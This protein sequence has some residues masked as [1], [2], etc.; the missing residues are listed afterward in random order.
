MPPIHSDLPIVTPDPPRKTASEKYGGLYYLGIGGLAVLIILV[1]WFGWGL[2]TLRSVFHEVYVLHDRDRP[3]GDRIEAAYRLSHNPQ[4]APKQA[5]EMALRKPLPELARYL[6]AESLT[7]RI[8]GEDPRAYVKAVAYSEGWPNWLR[9]VLLRPVAY[10]AGQE[11]GLPQEPLASLARDKD[12]VIS[13]W[14]A[15]VSSAEGAGK[16]ETSAAAKRE[17][18][19]V[20]AGASAEQPLADLFLRALSVE[21]EDR[22]RLLDR[23][24]A[25]T[26]EHHAETAKLWEGWEERS[27]RLVRRPA[28]KLQLDSTGSS[29]SR[30]RARFFQSRWS[31]T[32]ASNSAAVRSVDRLRYD[33]ARL[34]VV[35]RRAGE[36]NAG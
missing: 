9:L 10:A 33:P 30:T 3:D 16:S 15:F 34:V 24:T 14:A 2:W 26:R 29:G 25:W 13:L 28:P 20:A 1:G 21:G 11:Y 36:S 6:L 22:Q 18:E 19:R 27:G 4:L 31:D 8:V 12:P 32:H 17:L 35:R 5:W 7:E 23:A